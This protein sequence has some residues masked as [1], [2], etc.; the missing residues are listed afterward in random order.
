MEAAIS[1][2]ISVAAVLL[3]E[4]AASRTEIT[5]LVEKSRSP[6]VV[7]AEKVFRS[8]VEAQTPQGIAAEIAIPDQAPGGGGDGV[9][10]EG[11]QDPG[12]VGAI[13]RS[14]AAF[15]IRT[16]FLDRECADPWSPKVLRAAMGGHFAVSIRPG[17]QP[18]EA[19]LVCA[20]AHGGTALADADLSGRLCWIFGAEGRGVSPQLQ[21]RA[22]L[23]VR[24]PLSGRVESLNVAAAAAICFYESFNRRGRES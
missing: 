4:E 3:S 12:N 15:G 16:V 19:K 5:R 17:A 1:N 22:D 13:V 6:V 24:I 9:F 8:I 7:L 18:P 10:L 14:A 23:L 20:V 11:V 21:R 2:G